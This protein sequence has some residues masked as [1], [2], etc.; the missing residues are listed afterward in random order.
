MYGQDRWIPPV[1]IDATKQQ[2]FLK[3]GGANR[4]VNVPVGTYYA[5]NDAT[6][7][8]TYPSIYITLK[9]LLDA[10]TGLVWSFEAAT[11]T[12]S[13]EQTL[14]GLK[15]QA[16][17]SWEL[18]LFSDFNKTGL[19]GFPQGVGYLADAGDDSITS[20]HTIKGIWLS[21][22]EASSKEGYPEQV[23]NRS[24]E[25]IELEDYYATDHGERLPREFVYE[26]ILAAHVHSTRA[27][28][29]G[30][31]Q[32]AGLTVGDTHNAFEDTWRPWAKGENIIIVHNVNPNTLNVVGEGY[33]VVRCSSDESKNFKRVAQMMRTGGE[34]YRLTMPCVIVDRGDYTGQ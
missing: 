6:L 10:A 30:Y 7:H 14:G 23:L 29:A 11:P 20:T 9:G 3:E 28:H 17:G 24:T 5:H 12:L 16:D 21:P 32:S 2:L 1:E 8:A 19:L 4:T 33:E 26:Y 15:I 34:Y 18:G 13:T 25:Y 27:N 31:A 22:E